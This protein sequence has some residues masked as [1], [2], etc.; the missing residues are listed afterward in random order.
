MDVIKYWN[1]FMTKVKRFWKD[2]L[3]GSRSQQ[4]SH[5]TTQTK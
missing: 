5:Q 4:G 2:V 1:F 3:S